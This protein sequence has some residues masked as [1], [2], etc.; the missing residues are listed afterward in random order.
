LIVVVAVAAAALVAV[1][2][3]L[4][5]TLGCIAGMLCRDAIYCNRRRTQHGLFVCLSVWLCMGHKWAVQK[6]LNWSRCCLGTDLCGSRETCVRWGGGKIGWIHLLPQGVMRWH[7]GLLPSYI[8]H[9][10]LI[11]ILMFTVTMIAT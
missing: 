6:R 4:I 8:G 9:M 1:V 10:L 3:V 2:V 7:C 5:I 11:V